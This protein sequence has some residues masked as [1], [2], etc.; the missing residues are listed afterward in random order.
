MWYCLLGDIPFSIKTQWN[1]K[2][3]KLS[4]PFTRMP[5]LHIP[6]WINIKFDSIRFLYIKQYQEIAK[7]NWDPLGMKPVREEGRKGAIVS[8]DNN[9]IFLT[10]ACNHCHNR[11]TK[12]VNAFLAIG[13]RIS[14]GPICI[15]FMCYIPSELI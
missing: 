14:R 3:V 15:I 6:N 13:L 4:Q 12:E 7:D 9:E 5:S 8:R 1:E 2:R 11:W 10:N